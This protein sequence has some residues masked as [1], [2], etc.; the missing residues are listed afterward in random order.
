M[1]RNSLRL[2]TVLTA[3]GLLVASGCT[4]TNMNLATNP[5]NWK[6][7]SLAG[8]PTPPGSPDWWK[9]HKKNAEFVPGKG[10]RVADVEGFF[11]QEGRPINAPISKIVEQKKENGLLG[12]I[13]VVQAVTD[14][15]SQLGMGPDQQKAQLAFQ[16]GE[17]LFRQQEYKG[18]AKQFKEAI[19][20]SSDTA[21][22]QNCLFY[23]GE[24][25]FFSDDYPDAVNSYTE[26]LEKYPN[27]P[28][29]DKAIRRQFD[30]AQYWEK[31]HAFEPHWATTPNLLDD[32]RPFFDTPG[33][34]L[35]TYENIR[36][37]DPTGPLADD[38]IMATANSHFLRG[39]YSDADYFYGLLRREYPRSE[40]QFEAHIL[41]LQCKIRIYQGPDY[42]A[43]PLQEAKKLVKQL[44]V[45]F[46]TELNTT[47]RERLAE[48][49]ATL[50]MQLATR[51]FIRAKGYDEGKHYESARFYYAQLVRDY[52][53]T[54]LA[55]QARKR[56]EE[57]GGKPAH[58]A[59][60]VQWLVDLFPESAERVAITQ[61]PLV[62]PQSQIEVANEPG[63][64][65]TVVR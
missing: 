57:L 5:A 50:A 46:G 56:Y 51:D 6:W 55:E 10:Y 64:A 54:P 48:I 9:K 2:F 60:K 33:R 24:S 17:D 40:H 34:S 20:R 25:Q 35:K 36:L 21:L 4:S 42:V 18:A 63:S 65:G 31:H 37:N 39:R 8:E 62:T 52:P 44:K 43:T 28:H 38:S 3:A 14:V 47:E 12:D 26:L 19:A 11:D 41:G 61:V 27:S 45:Q 13:Q 15:K 58:P 32:S 59:T 7:P 1:P 16:A 49:Q 29:L 53:S 30:I 22:E 23:L